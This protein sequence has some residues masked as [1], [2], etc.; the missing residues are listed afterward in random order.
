[1]NDQDRANLNKVIEGL[2]SAQ[3]QDNTEYLRQERRSIRLRDE[4][5]HMER[6]KR[7][8]EGD[9]AS[10]AFV[11]L[12]QRECS[13]LFMQYPL[14]FNKLVKD[15]LDLR[16]FFQALQ[17][18]RQIEDGAINQEEGS[19]IMGKLFADMYL[20]ASRREGAK[21]DEEREAERPPPLEG[22]AL[23]WKQFKAR[24]KT[25]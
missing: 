13:Y 3:Y 20:D 8:Y 25:F 1:M 17:T 7:S 10:E 2:D 24:A 22:K 21:W 16:L 11:E 19:V 5:L 4:V 15:L 12:C 9:R 14:I 18:L 23:S 6:L